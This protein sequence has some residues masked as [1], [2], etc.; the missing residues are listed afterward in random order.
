MRWAWLRARSGLSSGRCPVPGQSKPGVCVVVRYEPDLQRMAKALLLILRRLP[1]RSDMESREDT[2]QH[3]EI[4]DESEVQGSPGRRG[5]S[6]G[7]QDFGP[8]VADS[9]RQQPPCD[10]PDDEE[11]SSCIVTHPP[12]PL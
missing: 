3:K 9:R 11:T 5:G 8:D 10:I 1:Q 12:F 7:L 6:Q 4:H 2:S